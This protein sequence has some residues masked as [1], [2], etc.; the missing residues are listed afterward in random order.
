MTPEY[1]AKPAKP[2]PLGPIALKDYATAVSK[3]I[4]LAR[5]DVGGSRAAAQVLLS[6]YN[7]D[8][9]HVDLTDLCLLDEHYYQAAM[10]AIR[11]RIEFRNEP[12]EMIGGGGRIFEQL[13]EDW[14]HLHVKN[15]YAKHYQP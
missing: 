7:G 13:W 12:H 1:T 8:D 11:G 3:L 10:I 5:T 4:G 14:K 15:R 2:A 9:F 6:L